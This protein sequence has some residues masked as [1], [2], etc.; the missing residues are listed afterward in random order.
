MSCLQMTGCIENPEI[1]IELSELLSKFNNVAGQKVNIQKS[2]VFL[3][4]NNESSENKI[5]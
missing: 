3:Y 2:I 1:T 5:K 4:T